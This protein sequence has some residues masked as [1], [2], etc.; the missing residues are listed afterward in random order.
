[1]PICN[2]IC[3][4]YVSCSLLDLFLFL[5]LSP[6]ISPLSLP[7]FWAGLWLFDSGDGVFVAF[8]H[9]SPATM[10]RYWRDM[11]IIIPPFYVLF[12]L[13]CPLLFPWTSSLWDMLGFWFEKGC[14]CSGAVSPL[15][16][17]V[18]ARRCTYVR[19]RLHYEGLQSGRRS[20]ASFG[21]LL[22]FLSSR[23]PFSFLLRPFSTTS[24]PPLEQPLTDILPI[25]SVP[26]L[27]HL[28][29]PLQPDMVA[30]EIISLTSYPTIWH[31]ETSMSTSPKKPSRR[32]KKEKDFGGALD[33]RHTYVAFRELTSSL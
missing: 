12:F 33:A 21:C 15:R 23:S 32:R 4:G 22:A 30:S 9:S 3:Y 29:I 27:F 2:N 17:W 8:A 7:P 25:S 20:L 13:V 26:P 18:T 16:F 19:P 28:L 11:C 10:I 31:Y 24:S 6:V 1:M 5:S 14:I